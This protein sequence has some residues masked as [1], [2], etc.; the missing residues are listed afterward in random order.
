[1]A[2]NNLPPAVHIGVLNE[3]FP[4]EPTWT[5]EQ[6]P[7]LT[8]KVVIVTGG[9]TGIGKE[10]CKVLLSRNA[11]VYLAARSE[12]KANEA[13]AELRSATGK[14]AIF[15][16]LDLADLRSVR[17]AA[18]EF[19]SKE[20]HLHILFNNGGVMTPPLDLVTAQGYDGQFGTNVLGHFFLTQLLIPVLLR[21]AKGEISGV[22]CKVRVI[23]VSSSQHAL[24]SISGGIQWDSLEKGDG[25]LKARKRIGT[26]GLYSQSKLGNVLISKE[27]AERY[28]SQG[29][30]AISLHPGGV[31]TDLQRYA[32]A[33]PMGAVVGKIA[34]TML[35]DVSYGILT[36]LYA[37]T[38]PEAENMNGEY[39]T[40]WARRQV[41]SKYALL[42]EL[43]KRVWAWCEDQVKNF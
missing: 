10:S 34:N 39:L 41:P 32:K 30:V 3:I 21:T 17:R 22:P 28:G 23:T 36:Q 7:D 4:P 26:R 35:Y 6:V 25:A 5:S 27:L 8:G 31:K 9:N 11:K 1:M 19:L 33:G 37:G 15:L 13:I 40:A 43:R 24:F 20:Q 42:P 12:S 29:I 14:E 2:T 16:R 38:A 18:E